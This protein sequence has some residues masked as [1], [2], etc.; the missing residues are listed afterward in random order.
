MSMGENISVVSCG[1]TM[2]TAVPYF[3][4]LDFCFYIIMY[5]LFRRKILVGHII[6]TVQVICPKPYLSENNSFLASVIKGNGHNI[7]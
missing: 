1:K 4:C 2:G 5:I 6:S 7:F 3:I